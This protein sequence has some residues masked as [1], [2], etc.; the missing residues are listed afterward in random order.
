MPLNSPTAEKPRPHIE[1]A[2]VPA[3]SSLELLGAIAKH[4]PAYAEGECISY[5]EGGARA[6][7]LLGL[8]PEDTNGF[9]SEWSGMDEKMHVASLFLA[10]RQKAKAFSASMGLAPGSV[11]IQ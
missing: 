2:D 8:S 3:M 4:Y 9:M 6:A 11:I 1:P 5:L 10:A 7:T